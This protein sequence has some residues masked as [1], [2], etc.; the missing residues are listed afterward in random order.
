MDRRQFLT[1]GV[2][3]LSGCAQFTS[4]GS[5][6]VQD[7]DGDGVIDSKDY[8]PQD[9]DVQEKSDLQSTATATQSPTLSPSATSSPTQTEP[10]QFDENRDVNTPFA[11][12]ENE[13]TTIHSEN[14]D[15][16]RLEPSDTELWAW[17]Q[18]GE[19]T[20]KHEVRVTSGSFVDVILMEEDQFSKF[21]NG[22]D[23][24][25]Y[26]FVTDLY[27]KGVRDELT[28]PAGSY[29]FI[30]SNKDVGEETYADVSYHWIRYS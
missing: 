11:Q 1:V 14:K 6:D 12:S 19:Q 17:S 18:S 4:D 16:I 26:R 22:E 20:F 15:D 13:D 29:R 28:I 7:S 8:A 5:D 21:Q 30:L 24:E 3:A 10:Y 2:A 25:F 23:F 9:P 27:T